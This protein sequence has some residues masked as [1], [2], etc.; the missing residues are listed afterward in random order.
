MQRMPF[1]KRIVEP[2]LVSRLTAE[3]FGRVGE[4]GTEEGDEEDG[5]GLQRRKKRRSSSRRKTL[6]QESPLPSGGGGGS[7]RRRA[8]LFDTLQDVSGFTLV[9]LLRQL[10]D[11]SR[12]ASGIFQELEVEAG[13]MCALCSR[14]HSR[15]QTLQ[16]RTLHLDAKKVAVRK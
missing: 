7:R 15:F 2:R 12:L 10:A 6:E 8:I 14:L 1:Y 4:A 16:E 5:D 9:S 3:D 13:S 11:L